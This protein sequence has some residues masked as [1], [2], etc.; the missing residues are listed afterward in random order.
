VLSHQAWQST[1][2]SDPAI[3]GAT[4]I[5]EGH[6][7]TMIGVARPGF[8]GE[9]LRG[10]PPDLWI[11]LQQEPLLDGPDGLLHQSVSAWLRVIGRLRAGA[12]IDGLGPRLTGVLRQLYGVSFWDLLA[13]AVAAGSLA[14]CAF[15]AALIPA[16]RAASISPI[17]ALRTE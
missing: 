1:F 8:F 16:R 10:N 6:P 7:F 15:F 9:T 13:L 5:V 3:V 11:P 14:V 4:V 2:G 17:S 12:T